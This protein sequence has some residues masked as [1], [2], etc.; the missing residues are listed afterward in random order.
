MKQIK[1]KT[2]EYQENGT[3]LFPGSFIIF[4]L[5]W[6]V[7]NILQYYN[8]NHIMFYEKLKLK[9]NKPLIKI[10]FSIMQSSQF[11]SFH[12]I[13][14]CLENCEKNGNPLSTYYT[15]GYFFVVHSYNIYITNDK[16]I[17]WMKKKWSLFHVFKMIF[18]YC[19]CFNLNC[20]WIFSLLLVA[21]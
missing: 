1:Q 12:L 9:L 4:L 10:T 2:Q 5:S 17:T 7:M 21:G 19:Y 8:F 18:Y 11:R 14:G 16:Q 13:P 6:F 3:I 15:G 20:N